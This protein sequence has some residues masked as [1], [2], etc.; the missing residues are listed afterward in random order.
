VELTEWTSDG[1]CAT[2]DSSG[3][4]TTDHPG[5]AA[6]ACRRPPCLTRRGAAGPY[7]TVKTMC[8]EYTRGLKGKWSAATN[9]AYMVYVPGFSGK[10][11][12]SV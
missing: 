11:W 2:R 12:D 3:C 6:G 8:F 10:L 4:A 9:S 5:G 1:R 7:L